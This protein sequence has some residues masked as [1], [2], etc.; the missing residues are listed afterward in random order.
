M[1]DKRKLRMNQKE[2]L[3]RKIYKH[4][5]AYVSENMDNLTSIELCRFARKQDQLYLIFNR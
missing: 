3:A 4:N 1:S 5:K 2:K